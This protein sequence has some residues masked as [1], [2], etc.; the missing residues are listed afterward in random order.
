MCVCFQSCSMV[1]L[2]N[3]AFHRVG[4][5]PLNGTPCIIFGRA[6][7]CWTISHKCKSQ[8][9]QQE[10]IVRLLH[11]T[12]AL[13]DCVM[14]NFLENCISIFINFAVGMSN[15]CINGLKNL[16]YIVAFPPHEYAP[17]WERRIS[18][19]CHV[20]NS[21]TDSRLDSENLVH[22]VCRICFHCQNWTC[23]A[24]FNCDVR[25]G[26]GAGHARLIQTLWWVE[27]SWWWMGCKNRD[28]S[29]FWVRD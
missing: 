5:S 20:C 21:H 24:Y 14:W 13:S 19:D 1:V 2:R 23:L 6:E 17:V 4:G 15:D 10:R 18:R 29:R 22:V 26:Q 27:R 16:V 11:G 9:L 8:T 12:L 25:C 28:R 3:G 7:I